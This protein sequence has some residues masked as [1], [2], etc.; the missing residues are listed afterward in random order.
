M[1]HCCGRHSEHLSVIRRHDAPGPP[2]LTTPQKG[3]FLP[4]KRETLVYLAVRWYTR[5]PRCSPSTPWSWGWTLTPGSW[6]WPGTRVRG[7]G[8]T[9]PS[10]RR[11]AASPSHS[12]TSRASTGH[13]FL[14]SQQ[15]SEAR[16]EGCLIND[17][18]WKGFTNVTQQIMTLNLRK[19]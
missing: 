14:I 5:A 8:P 11:H 6:G 10:Q 9:C 13:S 19:L 2:L 18:H 7:H 1:A 4:S 16:T 15:M 17:L 3:W 12:A